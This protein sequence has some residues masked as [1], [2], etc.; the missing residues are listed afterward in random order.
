MR[1]IDSIYR[2]VNYGMTRVGCAIERIATTPSA[3]KKALQVADKTFAAFDLYF[4]GK[5]CEREITQVMKGI[6]DFI[7]FYGSYK[8]LMYWANLFSK[9]SIDQKLLQESIDSSLSASHLNPND[10]LNQ[11]ALSK[12][13]FDEV[14]AKESYYSNGEVIE[15]IKVSLEKHGYT[16]EKA[17]QVAE[18]IIVRQKVDSPVKVFYMACFTVADLGG[19]ILTLKKWNIL[20]LSK[21]AAAIGSQS[22]AFRFT[23]DLRADKVLG[24]IGSTG[25]ALA[26]GEAS[27]RAITHASKIYSAKTSLKEKDEAYKEL[28]N[29]FLNILSGVIDLAATAAPL[30]YELNSSALVALAL[31]SK[32]TGLVCLLVK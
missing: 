32:G 10:E 12:Q 23:V 2:T 7:G 25:I 8:N 6:V 11:K 13:V 30:I 14:M 9:D 31:I 29:A 16:S 4:K 18:R 5:T 19:N 15:A 27:Y 20:D 22:R 24:I 26:L 28:R 21:L 1:L 17:K 3:V